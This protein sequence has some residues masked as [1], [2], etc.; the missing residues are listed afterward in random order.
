[1]IVLWNGA[2]KEPVLPQV[3]VRML[4]FAMICVLLVFKATV[5]LG[6]GDDSGQ[7]T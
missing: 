5:E 6:R 2:L 7:V 1:M 3:A 4:I